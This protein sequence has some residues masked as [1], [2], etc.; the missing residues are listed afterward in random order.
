M[1][2]RSFGKLTFACSIDSNREDFKTGGILR[3]DR[4]E[5]EPAPW[6]ACGSSRISAGNRKTGEYRHKNFYCFHINQKAVH[7]GMESAFETI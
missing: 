3:C 1:K 7:C 6:T 4:R 5:K 2:A